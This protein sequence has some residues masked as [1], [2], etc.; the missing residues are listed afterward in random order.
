LLGRDNIFRILCFMIRGIQIFESHGFGGSFMFER[1]VLLLVLTGKFRGFMGGGVK[2]GFM[3]IWMRGF[4]DRDV[5]S[6]EDRKMRGFVDRG[7]WCW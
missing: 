6:W 4:K 7:V 3:D 1:C 5:R 2:S